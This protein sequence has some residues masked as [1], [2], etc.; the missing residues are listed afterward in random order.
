[1]FEQEINETIQ[2][3]TRDVLQD[4]TVVPLAEILEEPRIPDRFKAFFE[5]EARWW[6]YTESVARSRDRRFDYSNPELDSLLS[7]LEQVQVRHARFE[8]DDFIAVLDS[9]VKLTFNY[10]CRPQTTLKWYVFRG[11]PTKPIG[12]TLLRMD[13]FVD[14][15]YF[16]SVFGEW[17][18]RKKGERP[19]FDS[20][21][22]KEFERIIR[23]IDDQILLSCTID[24]LLEILTPL[25]DFIGKGEAQSLP[26][27]ALIVF[28]DDKN[29]RK[30]VDFLERE[31]GRRT[32]ITPNSFV[33]LMEELLSSS[34]D[35]PE[36]D[37]SS[38]YQDDA[39]D[40]VVREHLGWGSGPVEE[41]DAR[42]VARAAAE[43]LN[44][45]G[46]VIDSVQVSDDEEGLEDDRWE[47]EALLEREE[48]AAEGAVA[49]QPVDT[50]RDGRAGQAEQ[51]ETAP[52]LQDAAV[53]PAALPEE[54]EDVTE[55][56]EEGEGREE[57]IE[58]TERE[59][60]EEKEE[61]EEEREEEEKE[62]GVE[63]PAAESGT[64][65]EDIEER[66]E[67]DD[68][69]EDG[70]LFG[71]QG[72]G[73]DP[74]FDLLMEP[75]EEERP[76]AP[77]I[78]STSAAETTAETP[79][80]MSIETT[81]GMPEETASEPAASAGMESSE[82]D[83][84]STPEEPAAA[85]HAALPGEFSIAA[86][87]EE[88]DLMEAILRDEE[89]EPEEY[90]GEAP[91]IFDAEEF[92]IDAF[93]NMKE[94]RSEESEENVVP[95]DSSGET[96]GP[97]QAEP[98]VEARG[99]GVEEIAEIEEPEEMEI[100]EVRESPFAD[101]PPEEETVAQRIGEEWTDDAGEP[102]EQGEEEGAEGTGEEEEDV[103]EIP[104]HD[105][106]AREAEEPAVIEESAEE[107]EEEE[108]E[109]D[110][111]NDPE[112]GREEVKSG[113]E[114]TTEFALVDEPPPSTERTLPVENDEP[115]REEEE[116]TTPNDVRN[117]IDAMLERK[118]VKKIF[119]RNREGYEEM[120]NR[121]NEAET[122]RE[123]SRILDELFIRYD[124]DPYS[125]IAIRF[126]D[127]VY[128]RYLSG[129]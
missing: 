115:R 3:I 62:M 27:E 99:E 34:D 5:T 78:P 19:T 76:D 70:D 120:L 14:F 30:L 36:T 89:R 13:A 79:V 28:F 109:D 81:A 71:E 91:L 49:S 51:T 95:P 101:V 2:R 92:G 10:L 87:P 106:F 45:G 110:D 21:S 6:I 97:G 7:Y 118:V 55:E 74:I 32:H 124:V 108:E 16:R 116:K 24:D 35:E 111:E 121:L 42:R 93:E 84:A 66:E 102:E 65:A 18:D 22:A 123:A 23:R 31:R 85:E 41:E 63:I 56:I 72:D 104:A 73:G 33:L 9:A 94:N 86:A 122:W 114:A 103:E 46:V 77:S 50:D 117:Y 67:D 119:N 44:G 52:T 69:D 39:L 129:V 54:T 37:F 128:G 64:E 100:E 53:E 8:R 112:D 105:V 68:N 96:S 83:A 38:V 126:T 17:V 127:C 20:I 59:I 43:S 47:E 61:G 11:E 60:E 90:A 57:R 107:E 58:E 1:M 75:G 80:A 40:Q 82:P 29:I 113:Q 12:E 98:D 4:R 48:V 88:E 25:F 15:P 26:V 125:R